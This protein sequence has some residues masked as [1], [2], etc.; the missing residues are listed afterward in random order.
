MKKKKEEEKKRGRVVL[1]GQII[2]NVFDSTDRLCPGG[3][4]FVV[5]CFIVLCHLNVH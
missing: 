1:N 3:V 2:A 4:F 5:S